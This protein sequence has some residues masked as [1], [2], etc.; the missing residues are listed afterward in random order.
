MACCPALRVLLRKAGETF[1]SGARSGENTHGAS[2][3][4]QTR[5]MEASSNASDVDEFPL[6]NV[7]PGNEIIKQIDFQVTVT[8][9]SERSDKGSG[10]KQASLW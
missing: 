1:G 7:G 10:K 8:G 3:R 9:N 5:D 4:K 2:M 6:V